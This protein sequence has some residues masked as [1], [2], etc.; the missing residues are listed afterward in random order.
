MIWGPRTRNR[1]L[2]ASS[3]ICA[4]GQRRARIKPSEKAHKHF[5]GPGSRTKAESRASQT[6]LKTH[7]HTRTSSCYWLSRLGA[8]MA[9]SNEG[10]QNFKL[11]ALPSQTCKRGNRGFILKIDFTGP[12]KDTGQWPTRPRSLPTLWESSPLIRQLLL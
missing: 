5:L 12:S 6:S 1:G 4:T 11:R 10:G 2:K 7:K 8:K 9:Q 3:P